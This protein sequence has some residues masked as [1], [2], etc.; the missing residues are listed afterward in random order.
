[1]SLLH[2]NLTV[3][4]HWNKIQSL[5]IP[6]NYRMSSWLEWGLGTCARCLQCSSPGICTAPVSS[7][8]SGLCSNAASLVPLA[9]MSHPWPFAQPRLPHQI[10]NGCC[11]PSTSCSFLFSMALIDQDYFTSIFIDRLFSLTESSFFRAR[12][13]FPCKQSI[14]KGLGQW[15]TQQV[16]ERVNR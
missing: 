5:A 3:A 1:M 14:L 10:Y 13:L 4:S 11:I 7:L 8:G 15:C 12:T 16:C 9:L 2:W 6:H